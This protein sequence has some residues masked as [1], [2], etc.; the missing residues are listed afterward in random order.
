MR[1]DRV[2]E[3]MGFEFNGYLAQKQLNDDEK[4]EKEVAFLKAQVMA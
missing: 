1:E 4:K 3:S 2:A